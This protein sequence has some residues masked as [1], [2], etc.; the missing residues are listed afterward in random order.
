MRGFLL[1]RICLGVLCR[2]YTTENWR[3]KRAT[4]KERA[5]KRNQIN[6]L[7]RTTP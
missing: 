4:Q 1:C 5:T 7:G 3:D 2:S 6:A